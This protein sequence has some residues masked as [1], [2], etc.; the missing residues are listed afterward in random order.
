MPT[1][2]EVLPQGVVHEDF[3]HLALARAAVAAANAAA[4]QGQGQ[5]R[6]DGPPLVAAD[7]SAAW[8]GNPGDLDDVTQAFDRSC[9]DRAYQ[10]ALLGEPPGTS[11]D[12]LALRFQADWLAQAE[13]AYR[14][15]HASP[16]R[17]L[18]HAAARRRG[19]GHTA[20]HYGALLERLARLIEL[21]DPAQE[22]DE[23]G[24]GAAPA[25]PEVF[26]T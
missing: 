5:R 9:V 4:A 6:W 17:A 14:D 19:H 15:R 1:T 24:S 21:G 18:A 13:R 3:C 23:A 7:G 2:S 26:P 10:Q 25:P 16:V 11:A 20:G 8:T 12:C 22:G